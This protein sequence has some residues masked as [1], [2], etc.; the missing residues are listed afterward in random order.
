M[1]PSIDLGAGVSTV[2][3]S[4]S[5][6]TAS[7]S[8]ALSQTIF[9]GGSLKAQLESAKARRAALLANYEQAI[10]TSLREVDVA[11][12]SINTSAL[13]EEEVQIALSAGRNALDSAELRYRVGADDLTSLLSAQQSYYASTQDALEARRDRLAAS[14]DLYVALGGSY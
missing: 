10:L 5:D 7:L 12:S 8:A 3:T 1:L 2:L 4:L 14:I 6:P 11:L 13:R 9:S